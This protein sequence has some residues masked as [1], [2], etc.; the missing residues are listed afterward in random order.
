MGPEYSSLHKAD[1][2]FFFKENSDLCFCLCAFCN[3][4]E[5]KMNFYFVP[6]WEPVTLTN[7]VGGGGKSPNLSKYNH[8]MYNKDV[9]CFNSL[10]ASFKKKKNEQTQRNLENPL[11]ILI[12]ESV[13]TETSVMWEKE[14]RFSKIQ[15][16]QKVERSLS[17]FKNLRNNLILCPYVFLND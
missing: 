5:L 14:D 6:L 16:V 8:R 4:H 2:D 17:G 1:G 12:V 15:R 9:G 11:V 7:I 3:K 10:Q 13:A